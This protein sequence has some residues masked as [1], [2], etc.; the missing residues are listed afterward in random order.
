M[1]G[2]KKAGKL[3]DDSRW[4]WLMLAPN[5][6]GFFMFMLMPVVATFVISFLKYDMLTKPKFIGLTNYITMFHDPIVWQVTRNTLIYTVTMYIEIYIKFKYTPLTV[7]ATATTG[8][9]HFGL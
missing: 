4:A 8:S 6:I 5:I 2:K 9:S 3:K 1:I 7:R